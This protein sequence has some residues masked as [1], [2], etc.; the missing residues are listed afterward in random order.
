[1]TAKTRTPTTLNDAQ[2]EAAQGGY[3]II[4]SDLI[5]SSYQTGGSSGGTVPTEEFSFNYERIK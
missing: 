1:M 4:F 2:L 5:V 3:K